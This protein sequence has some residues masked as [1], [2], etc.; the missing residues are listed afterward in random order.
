MAVVEIEERVLAEGA[1][2]E[3][4]A[5][6]ISACLVAQGV[7][8]QHDFVVL[9]EES[10]QAAVDGFDDAKSIAVVGVFD[11]GSAGSDSPDELVCEI[12]GIVLFKYGGSGH[13]VC[14]RDR[15]DGQQISVVVVCVIDS[16]REG[17]VQALGGL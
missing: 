4:E 2:N 5:V 14:V 17:S 10:C 11:D 6:D 1:R 16:S 3:V 8:F 7:Q 12:V 13:T 9:I 15:C